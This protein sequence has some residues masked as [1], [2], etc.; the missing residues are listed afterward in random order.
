LS[1][2]TFLGMYSICCLA[3]LKVCFAFIG[4]CLAF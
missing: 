2:I 4:L 3:I 1:F